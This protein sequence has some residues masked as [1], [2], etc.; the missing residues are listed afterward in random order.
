MGLPNGVHHLAIC[1][2]DIKKQIEFFTKVLG[3]ELVALYWMHGVDNTFHGFLKLNDSSYIA[4]VQN[5]EIKELKAQKGVSHAGWTAGNVPGGAM[6][7]LAFNVD[8]EVELIA[9][10][11]RIR[12]HGHFVYGPLNHGLCKSI[13]FA[14]PEGMMLEF[15]TSEGVGIDAEQWIDPEVVALCGISA[16]ELDGYKHPASFQSKGGAVQNPTVDPRHPPMEFPAGRDSVYTM[17]DAEVTAR[18][19]EPDPPVPA[20]APAA[21][22]ESRPASAK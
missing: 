20:R 11:D 17:T 7:H 3:A 16:S 5:P 9:M 2:A 10:R 12:A 22:G 19:S 1:T 14:G 13:Y 4:F 21:T 8:S 18:M 15:A 6:Q